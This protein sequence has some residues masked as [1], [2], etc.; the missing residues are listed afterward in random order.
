MTVQGLD[1]AQSISSNASDCVEVEIASDEHVYHE[2]EDVV[3]SQPMVP[4]VGMEFDTIEEA[5]RVYNEY[6]YKLGFSISVA[7]QRTSHVTKEVIRKE[8]ECSHARKPNEEGGVSTSSST[9]TAP[10]LAHDLE[11]QRASKKK[12][13]S[14]VLTTASRKR[15]T[16]KKYDCKAHMAAGLRDGKW[17]VIVMQPEHTHPLVK[18]L[19]RRKLLRSHRSISWADYELLKTLH[20]RNISTTQI[21]G[22][23][24]DFHGGVGNLTFSTTDVSNMRTHLQVWAEFQGYG[25]NIGVFSEVAS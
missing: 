2:D 21:M 8:F 18:K 10:Q 13:A 7:S 25:C 11:T 19:V 9:Q 5:R 24:A 1:I 15:K 4:Y 16:I 6:A 17:K 14:A 22:I 20:H 3:C 23:L 12:S